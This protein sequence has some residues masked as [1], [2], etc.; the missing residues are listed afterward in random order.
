MRLKRKWSTAFYFGMIIFILPFLYFTIRHSIHIDPSLLTSNIIS[1]EQKKINYGPPVH[2]KIPKIN[3]D[4]DLEPVGL[5]S[6]GAVGVPKDPHDVAWFNLSPHPGEDGNAIIVGHYGW[7]DGK[8]VAFNNLHKLRK[9]DRLYVEDDKGVT[10]SFVVRKI[11]RYGS[12]T[13]ASDVFV[14]N[15]GGSHLNLITCEGIW[16]K[17]SKS[18]SRRLIVFTDKE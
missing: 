13:D 17:I 18:Y 5:T 16:D 2:L 8:A 15:D 6:Q 4:V 10:T 12:E 1:F 11:L 7:K 3:I 9:G 14:S